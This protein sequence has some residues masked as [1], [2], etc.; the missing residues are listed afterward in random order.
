MTNIV[1]NFMLFYALSVNFM[2]FYDFD[3]EPK[4][5]CFFKI[6]CRV[7]GLTLAVISQQY[8]VVKP[9]VY[10]VLKSVMAA[11]SALPDILKHN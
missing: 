9:V 4:I 10:N 5:L 8:L 1:R 7:A 6:L 3:L 11:S 2:L